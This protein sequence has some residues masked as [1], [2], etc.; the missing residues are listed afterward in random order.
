M[1]LTPLF[2]APAANRTN[3]S[4]LLSASP[5]RKAWTNLSTARATATA[6]TSSGRL[7]T[8]RA[9]SATSRTNFRTLGLV[10]TAR[11]AGALLLLLLSVVIAARNDVVLVVT[12]FILC[13]Q[14]RKPTQCPVLDFLIFIK[15]VAY[16]QPTNNH[17]TLNSLHPSSP[18]ALAQTPIPSQISPYKSISPSSQYGASVCFRS[19]AR[20]RSGSS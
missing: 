4:R 6:L 8:I 9:V 16:S 13:L 20:L 2:P 17:S 5:S 14:E 7:S 10:N 19:N 3:S 1:S 18:T 11:D 15:V 12:S